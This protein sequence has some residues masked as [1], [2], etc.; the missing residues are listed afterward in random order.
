MK[1]ILIIDDEKYICSS[2]TYALEDKYK[3]KATT[4]P[5]EGINI[6]KN[7]P[8]DLV[9][10]DLKIGEVDGL[11]LLGE[12]KKINEKIVV[13]IM[14]AYGSI[15]SS[16]D[17]MKKGAYTYLT[18]PLNIEELYITIEQA[19]NF[20]DLNEKVEYLNEELK[21]KYEYRGIIGKSKSM[22]EIFSFIER[23]K[24]V[25]TG[26]LI[27]GESGTGKELVARAIHFSGKRKDKNF[28]EVNC[29]AI[30]EG[31]LE[32]EFF[33]HKKGTFTNAIADKIGKFQYADQGTI[34]L[35]E[36]GD[37]SLG[38]QSKL[39]RVLQDK[40]F[41]PLG[42]NEIITTDVRIISATNKDLKKMVEEGKFR[43]DL[44]FRLNIVEV[45]LSPL[46]ERKDDLSL[47][48]KHFIELYNKEMDKN[49]IGLTSEAKRVLLD[50]NYPGN[51]RELSNIIER[52][53]ILAVD[54]K[55][56]VDSLPYNVIEKVKEKE[57]YK[58][59]FSDE[60]IDELEN[61]LGLTLK[62]AERILIKKCLDKNKGHRKNTAE[63]LGI[64][65]RGLRNKIKEY[66]L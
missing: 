9:L 58:N 35:D 63:M 33:G 57:K 66:E 34:F 21:N 4:E 5:E 46:R 40:K 26:V 8:I 50:Y 10:L 17:A 14:T 44:Y 39:L 2:L 60:D 52:G 25:D 27:S 20:K 49:I 53:V 55:I 32:E 56:D 29:A 22:K 12:I 7:L 19:L 38:L 42:S 48:I 54:E 47:L 24:D 61:L 28:V 18:K 6:I 23:L 51:I 64:S 13:I 15:M 11:E 59:N 37:M 30:P 65:E 1:K 41:I 3:I 43:R 62:D 31:L 36:I 45:K 16:V